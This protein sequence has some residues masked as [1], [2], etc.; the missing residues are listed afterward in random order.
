MIRDP[1]RALRDETELDQILTAP[2]VVLYKHSTRCGISSAALLE[3][4]HFAET[5]VDMPV[6]MVDVIAQRL[7]SQAVA[8]RLGVRHESP[9]AIVLRNGAAVWSTS[10][11]RVTAHAI[12]RA[13]A[14]A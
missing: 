11:F 1:V 10:H 7:L 14:S 12:E 13:V 9:Q 3:V 5:H 8:A 6:Y 2:R 4:R